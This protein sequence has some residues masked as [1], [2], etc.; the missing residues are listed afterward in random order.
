MRAGRVEE[1][2]ALAVRIGKYMTRHAKNSLSNIGAET[3]ANDMWAAVRKLTGRQQE[4]TV[5]DGVSAESLNDHYAAISTDH[6]YSTPFLKPLTKSIEP[7]YITEWHVF[8]ILDHLRPTITGLDGL[9]AWFLRLGAPFFC[10]PV[11]GLFNLSLVTSTVPQQ[12]KQATIRPIPKVNPPKQHADFR[13]I[14]ITP[15]LTRIMERTVVH[16]FIYPALLLPPPTLSFSDQF[17]FRPT[18]ST[19]AAIITLL[20]TI[21]N[22]LLSQPYVTVISLDF[23][24]AFDT[25]RHST[26]LETMAL[27]LLKILAYINKFNPHKLC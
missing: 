8:Q 23:S 21:T 17:A 14:S 22:M 25:V 18:G 3:N 27:I 26:L 16:S 7:E 20:N 2:G 11:A 6:S 9:P 24:K 15:V 4:P 13:P 12:W 10:R 5:V 19:T 1:A